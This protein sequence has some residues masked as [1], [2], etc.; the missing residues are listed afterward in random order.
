MKL[1][2]SRGQGKHG[3][4]GL[5]SE[6]YV[7]D[8]GSCS[9]CRSLGFRRMSHAEVQARGGQVMG[10]RAP[11]Q[12]DAPVSKRQLQPRGSQ[13]RRYHRLHRARLSSWPSL[14]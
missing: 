5:Y 4:M 8:T 9:C 10:P 11:R 1:A 13:P 6:L 12:H 14:A 7:G 3:L 2:A